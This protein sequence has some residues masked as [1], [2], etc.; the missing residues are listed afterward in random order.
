MVKAPGLL[1]WPCI[2]HHGK[3]EEEA[4]DDAGEDRGDARY[5]SLPVVGS[6]PGIGSLPSL[7]SL[8]LPGA[9][10]PP[11]PSD[12]TGLLSSITQNH[13]IPSAI[14]ST[15]TRKIPEA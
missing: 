1:N 8:P 15:S 10:T 9:G 6:L 7:G 3:L 2:L 12:L 13:P 4:R 14:G 5:D 11:S